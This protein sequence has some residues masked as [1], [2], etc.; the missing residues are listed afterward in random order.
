MSTLVAAPLRYR[1]LANGLTGNLVTAW[2]EQI[3]KKSERMAKNKTCMKDFGRA[4][5][6]GW[7]L[8]GNQLFAERIFQ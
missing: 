5:V 8:D 2:E 7:G 3:G 4:R 6:G 1:S